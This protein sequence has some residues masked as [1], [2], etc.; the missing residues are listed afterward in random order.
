MADPRPF[1]FDQDF[2]DAGQHAPQRKKRVYLANEVD[3]IRTAAFSEGEGAITARAKQTEAQALTEIAE[4]CRQALGT[5]AEVARDHR[6][7]S[8]ELALVAA[9]KIA[10]GALDRFPEAPIKAALEALGREIEHQ[11]RLVIRIG[12]PSDALRAAVESAAADAG[13]A[14]QVA[15]RADPE[16]GSA[17]AFVIEWSDGRAAFDPDEVALRIQ[18]SFE[19]ALAADGA[20]GE[21]LNQATHLSTPTAG[22]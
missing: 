17:A 19:A 3:L 2:G 7:G 9:R 16:A 21:A 14:G 22:A 12:D 10:G 5:L 20:H 18:Q 6:R 1:N 4:A 8:A 15:F 11:P 13:F